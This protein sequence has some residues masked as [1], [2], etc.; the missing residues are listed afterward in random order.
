MSQMRRKKEEYIK[1]RKAYTDELERLY[2]LSFINIRTFTNDESKYL[3][4]LFHKYLY[5]LNEYLVFRERLSTYKKA[6]KELFLC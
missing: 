5:S 3:D 6:L 2:T 1:N 4:L